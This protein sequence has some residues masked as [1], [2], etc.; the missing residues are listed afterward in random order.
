MF[1]ESTKFDLRDA[2]DYWEKDI[3]SWGIFSVEVYPRSSN[4]IQRK[5][6]MSW[7]FCPLNDLQM[8]Q[9]VQ[10]SWDCV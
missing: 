5:V 7:I 9:Q 8:G 2:M 6:W 10:N 1:Q 3:Y 4:A